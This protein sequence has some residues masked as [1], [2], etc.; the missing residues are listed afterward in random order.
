MRSVSAEDSSVLAEIHEQLET[1][2][3]RLDTLEA[4]VAGLQADAAAGKQY[5]KSHDQLHR[6][7]AA[8]AGEETSKL[9]KSLAEIMK[10]LV[11]KQD[12]NVT[13]PQPEVQVQIQE[14]ESVI[15]VEFKRDQQGRLASPF[16]MR[17]HSE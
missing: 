15:D 11:K 12:I 10:A 2:V 1:I 8:A 5:E 3:G 13:V 6:N 7:M 9:R 14:G 4:S 16:R 17:K